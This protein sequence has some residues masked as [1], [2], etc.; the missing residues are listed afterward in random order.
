MSLDP[1]G[2]EIFDT[3]RLADGFLARIYASV[4]QKHV[5]PQ[6]VTNG[7]SGVL[8]SI[9]QANTLSSST[10]AALNCEGRLRCT[11]RNIQWINVYWSCRSPKEVGDGSWDRS[12]VW[13]DP[14][15]GDYGFVTSGTSGKV[16][17]DDNLP[18]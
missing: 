14:V 18:S 5:S 15:A 1:N 2:T 12:H 9:Q 11:V 8:R 16:T 7:L 13:P 10:R 17:W 6:S 3:Q 4:F